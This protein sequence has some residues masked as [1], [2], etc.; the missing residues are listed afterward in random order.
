V[1]SPDAARDLP[2]FGVVVLT[3]ND[4]P[5]EMRRALASLLGQRGCRLDVVVVGNGCEPTDVPPGVRALALPENVGIPEGRNVGAAAVA[6]RLLFFLDND[7]YLP[8]PTTLAAIAALF[9]RDPRLGYAQPR[10]VDPDGRPT[11]RRWVPRLRAGD[12]ERSSVA[13]VMSEGVVVVRRA[14]FDE[15]GGWPGQF[16]YGH[17]GI[18]LAWRM[19]DA[20]WTGYY[21]A[22]VVLEHPATAP[23]RHAVY[24]R[25]NAR[26]R[27]WVAFR[28]LPWPLVAPYLLNWAALTAVRLRS[29]ALLRVWLRGIREGF[30]GGWGA[31][32]PMR[33]STVARLTMAGR[34]PVI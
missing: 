5:A 4:R 1:P 31:R 10:I 33:W 22:D 3:M 11:P 24:Y 20:G 8:S 19:W 2:D 28:N 32:R 26:N 16:F 9:D 6:G 30:A 12:P 29:P 21:A 15:V 18:D 25:L 14:A 34:P 23:S 17:E 7:A 27:V 13:T